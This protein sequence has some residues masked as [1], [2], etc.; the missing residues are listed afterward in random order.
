MRIYD[1]NPAGPASAN[2]STTGANRGAASSPAAG[3]SR[4]VSGLERGAGGPAAVRQATGPDSVSLSNLAASLG[5]E[6]VDREAELERLSQLYQ[7]GLYE[8]D[9]GV[10]AEGLLEEGLAAGEELK[11]PDGGRP[12]E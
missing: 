11:P 10:V 8:A 4:P 9:P 5:P 12:Q 2:H 6:G 1:Q 7:R 3:E